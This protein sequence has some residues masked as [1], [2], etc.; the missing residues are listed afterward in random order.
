[1]MVLHGIH[2]GL[3]TLFGA[4]LSHKLLTNRKRHVHTTTLGKGQKSRFTKIV[5]YMVLLTCYP[6]LFLWVYNSLGRSEAYLLTH[7]LALRVVGTLLVFMGL[8]VYIVAIITLNSAWRIGID[9]SSTHTLITHGIYR[10]SRNPAYLG[11]ILLFIGLA[12]SY[13]CGLNMVLSALAIM[14]LLFMAK[15]EEKF[16]LMIHRES[17]EVYKEKV[18]FLI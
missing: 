16:L 8:V 2:L 14:S 6:L 15:Q 3:L 7:F 18:R 4:F 11:F 13:P 1:M 10:Y 9:A 5:E 17:Y 12:L